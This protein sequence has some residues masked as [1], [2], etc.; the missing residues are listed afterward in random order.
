M[1][2]L[3]N[4]NYLEP[5]GTLSLGNAITQNLKLSISVQEMWYEQL[6]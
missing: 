5:L 2:N 6:T 3:Q 1:N 4:Q